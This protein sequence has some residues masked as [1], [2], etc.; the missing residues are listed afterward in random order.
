MNVEHFCCVCVCGGGVLAVRRLACMRPDG[1]VCWMSRLVCCGSGLLL[2][3]DLRTLANRCGTH[4][5]HG[6]IWGAQGPN[7]AQVPDM[8]HAGPQ[9]HLAGPRGPPGPHATMGPRAH[10]EFP[11]GKRCTGPKWGPEAKI[12]IV[13][14]SLLG[15]GRYSSCPAAGTQSQMGNN[16]SSTAP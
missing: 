3:V 15:L 5:P 12:L 16:R 6:R 13:L 4:G 14:Y 1:L 11:R 8:D 2:G 7:K 9:D 10:P